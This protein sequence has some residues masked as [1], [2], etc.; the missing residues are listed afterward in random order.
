MTKDELKA[1]FSDLESD[2][3]ERTISTTNTDKFGQAIC[4]FANDLPNHRKPGYL[5]LGVTDDG[6]VQGIDVTD[7]E[8]DA[9]SRENR[10]IKQQ[11]SVFGFFDTLHD[12]RPHRDYEP[13]RVVWSR[14]REQ[15]PQCERLQEYRGRRS[16]E[17]PWFC[18]PP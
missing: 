16:D 10:D 1:L 15:L 4:A 12:C 5:F 17:S 18:Q 2:H 7:E 3:I 6:N 9:E 11:L 8:L 14:Q 13:R